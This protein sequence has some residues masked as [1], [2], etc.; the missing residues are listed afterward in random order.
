[1][2]FCSKLTIFPIEGNFVVMTGKSVIKGMTGVVLSGIICS[3]LD[4]LCDAVSARTFSSMVV[5]SDIFCL[6][7]KII[8]KS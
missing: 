3:S 4:K 5:A 7:R 6:A 8:S 1:M 2:D